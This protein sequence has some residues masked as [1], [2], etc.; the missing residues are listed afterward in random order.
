MSQTLRI[1]A[2]IKIRSLAYFRRF[3]THYPQIILAT[4]GY[5]A[6]ETIPAYRVR[7]LSRPK[8]ATI[9]LGMDLST[10]REKRFQVVQT[11]MAAQS[12]FP[13]L[14]HSLSTIPEHFSIRP[15][16]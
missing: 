12:V 13:A 4:N 7:R 9:H 11:R 8:L 14:F 10:F 6:L 16:L 3:S 1:K 15:I 2:P 5:K